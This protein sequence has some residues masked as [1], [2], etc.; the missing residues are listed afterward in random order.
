MTR[1][2]TSPTL[3]V[4]IGVPQGSILG[5]VLFILYINNIKHAL[6]D[7]FFAMYADDFSMLVSD[8]R[9]DILDNFCRQS[10]YSANIFFQNHSLYLNP[11]KTKVVRFHNRQKNC[12]SFQ[13]SVNGTRL[14]NETAVKFLGLYVDEN[15]T[16]KPHCEYLISK[17]SSLVYLFK[18]V[19]GVLT[20]KQMITLYY[21]QVESRLRYGICFWGDSTLS[22]KIFLVQKR[23]LRTIG[24]ISGRHSCRPLFSSYGVLTLPGLYVYE[25]CSYV[26]LNRDMFQRVSDKHVIN[27]RQK[28]KF[29]IPF[30]S[31]DVV[32][33]SPSYSGMRI[34]NGLPNDLRSLT[35]LRVFKCELKRY[36]M[37]RCIYRVSE[38]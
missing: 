17:L 3:N 27:T 12:V 25:I 19:R 5:P 11:N 4:S 36:L 8:E 28:D 20:V 15:L 23:I 35:S 14:C 26:Y 34:F 38:L 31:L 24:G 30:S 21:A 33:N 6:G 29:H 7:T 16:W 22:Q 32:I 13:F 37:D 10:L 2:Y 9:D 18:N 1:T